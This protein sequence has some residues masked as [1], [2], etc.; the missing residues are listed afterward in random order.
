M[1]IE[2][3]MKKEKETLFTK[4]EKI[5][6]GILGCVM[7]FTIII[8]MI[9]YCHLIQYNIPSI[10]IFGISY[11]FFRKTEQK[12]KQLKFILPEFGKKQFLKLLEFCTGVLVLLFIGTIMSSIGSFFFWNS[13]NR[14]LV[15]IIFLSFEG[16]F[17]VFKFVI[18]LTLVKLFYSLLLDF[19]K[20]K[21]PH[22]IGSESAFKLSLV[23]LMLIFLDLTYFTSVYYPILGDWCYLS[24]IG[25]GLS[26]ICFGINC[27]NI[28]KNIKRVEK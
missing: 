24:L 25:L 15:W 14:V 10:F 8:N 7:I 2:K 18:V 21:R 5:I 6:F 1:E 20:E 17:I 4:K 19:T 3:K 11:Y 27:I 13:E 9:M 23:G 22:W 12:I 28:E 16:V 26:I